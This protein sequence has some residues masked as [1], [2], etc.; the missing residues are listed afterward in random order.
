MKIKA[1]IDCVGIGYDLK[2]DEEAEVSQHTGE[3]LVKFGYAE[4]IQ[5]SEQEE[6]EEAEPKPKKPR[7]K[8][9]SDE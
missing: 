4:E 6:K 1:L 2:A 8:K 7:N 5:E 3:K 9:E